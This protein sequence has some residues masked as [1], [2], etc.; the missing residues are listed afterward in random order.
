VSWDRK[1]GFTAEKAKDAEIRGNRLLYSLDSSLRV[2]RVLGGESKF[3][4]VFVA[5]Q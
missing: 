5:T 1:F 2:L 3:V 4:K